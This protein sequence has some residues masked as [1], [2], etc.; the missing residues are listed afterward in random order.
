M[1]IHQFDSITKFFAQR[2]ITRRQAIAGSAAGLAAAGLGAAGLAAAQDASPEAD[3]TTGTTEHGP[4]MLFVQTYQGGTITPKEGTDR[5]ELVLERGFGQT[6]YFSD[7]PDRIVGTSDTPDFLEGLGFMENNPPNAAIVV[8]TGPDTHD[9][10]VIELFTPTYD[11]VTQGVTYEIVFLD[12]WEESLEFGLTHAPTA[13]PEMET[14][15]GAASLFID[16][17]P[18]MEMHCVDRQTDA[19]RGTI[20]NSV[21]DGFCYGWAEAKCLPC[22]P[23]QGDFHD[24]ASYWADQCNQQFSSCDGNCRVDWVCS[25][26]FD[27]GVCKRR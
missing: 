17:C 14:S 18:D 11:P 27:I 15:F 26:G 5:Y 4:T 19:I 13:L 8:E 9:I 16:D 1:D 2:Q 22:Q 7:R 24:A 25:E 21:H 6:I 20:E 12:N 10:A 3:E 23:W